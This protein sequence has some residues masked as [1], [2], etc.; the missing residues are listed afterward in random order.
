[1]AHR[2]RVLHGRP[3]WSLT[4]DV[5]VEAPPGKPHLVVRTRLGTTHVHDRS[6][7]VREGLRRM[8]LGPVALENVPQLTEAFARWR[9]GNGTAACPEWHRFKRVLDQ[10]GEFVVAS[11][12]TADDTGPVLSAVPAKSGC[13]FT[14]PAVGPEETMRLAPFTEFISVGGEEVIRSP[15]AP[16]QVVFHRPIAASVAHAIAARPRN[17]V[18]V[19]AA[20]DGIDGGKGDVGT[21]GD[22]VSYL[23]GAGVLVGRPE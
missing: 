21:I 15:L 10:L 8:V 3:L 2:S 14:F 17:V 23:A 5:V 20:L 7:L 4:E 19:A 6:T 18:E 9:R 12:G 11:L 13:C 1:M 22:I 16:Y